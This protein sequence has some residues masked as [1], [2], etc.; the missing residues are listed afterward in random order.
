MNKLITAVIFSSITTCLL[1]QEKKV[2]TPAGDSASLADVLIS[3]IKFPEKKKNISQKIEVITDAYI[4]KANAQNSGDLLQSTG[5]IFVQK[6]QQGGSSPVIRG[7]EA[8]RVLLMVDG[9]RMNNA[10]YRSGHLQNAIT[11]D[12]NMLERIEVMYGPGSTLHGSDALGGVVAYKTKSPGLSTKKD[13]LLFSGSAMGRYSTVNLE[14]TGHIDINIGGK[15][16]GVLISGTYSDFG[17]MRMGNNYPDK[18]PNFGRRPKYVTTI[19]NVD[20]IVDNND[21]RIQR[22]SG[23]KQWDMMGKILYQQNEKVSHLVNI[24]TSNSTT[25]PRY[26]RLQDISNGALRYANWYYGPQKRNM[27]AYEYNNNINATTFFKASTSYQE[28]EESRHQRDRNNPSQLHRIEKIK[29]WAAQIAFR[30]IYGMHEVN[31]GADVQ[32]NDV[33]SKA[34]T[35]NINSGVIGKLDTRYPDGKNRFNNIGIYVQHLWKLFEGKLVI[36]DGIRLQSVTLR[37]TLIDTSIQFRL[38]FTELKQNPFGVAGNI[39]TI[40]MPKPDIR[41]TAGISTGFRAPNIDDVAKVFESTTASR[42]LIVPNADLKP[43]KTINAEIGFT[44]AFEDKIK[45]DISAFYTWFKDAIAYAPFQFNGQDS[46]I[47]NGIK[48]GVKASQN[49]AKARLHGFSGGLTFTPVASLSIYGSVTYTYGKYTKPNGVKVPLDHIP[50]VF[51]KAGISYNKRQFST[52]SCTVRFLLT[53]YCPRQLSVTQLGTPSTVAYCWLSSPSGL[54][55]AIL[56]QPLYI[57]NISVENCLL[58]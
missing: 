58:L 49:V 27:Y 19:N 11:V 15:K 42:Q 48:V 44:K 18:Y 37:S 7:F 55:S 20:Y 54:Y 53:L 34:Y 26:D 5:N 17:D 57:A 25:V 36:N 50:P 46:V 6:S 56:F 12:Q 32:L 1:A 40:Y 24:Q 21:D 16:L 29:V 23:Y 10:V 31:F 47:Y 39:G 52:A 45:V 4:R 41:F 22:Y 35:E 51:G 28:I 2:F 3:A 33:K 13:I 38:P 43:E 14:K 8:S 9:V 30:K